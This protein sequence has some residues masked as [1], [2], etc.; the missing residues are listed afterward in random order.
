M[1]LGIIG[2]GKIIVDALYAME[3]ID[4]IICNAIWARPHSRKRGEELPR[5]TQSRKSIRIMMNFFPERISTPS[6]SV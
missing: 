3:P 4:E 6:T 2:T 5:S 1:K